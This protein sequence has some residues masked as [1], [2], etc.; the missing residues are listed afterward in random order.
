MAKLAL[1]AL[2]I[3]L[4]LSCG[5]AAEPADAER[6]PAL[7][8]KFLD[9]FNARNYDEALDRALAYGAAVSQT[10][11]QGSRE[12][13][14]FQSLLAGTFRGQ[15]KFEMAETYYLSAVET[16][17]KA[18]GANHADVADGYSVT[19]SFYELMSGIV[20]TGQAKIEYLNKAI[21]HAERALSI[22]ETTLGLADA[23][24]RSS[25]TTLAR[26]LES[27]GDLYAAEDMLQRLLRIREETLGTDHLEVAET[28]HD[29]ASVS[30][31]QRRFDV[32]LGLIDRAIGI[33]QAE[34]AAEDARLTSSLNTRAVVLSA[35]GDHAAAAEILERILP[36]R[37]AAATPNDPN[38]AALLANLAADYVET[39][40]TDK[41]E[42][43]Y[44]RVAKMREEF[45]G[46]AHPET[47]SARSALARLL[48]ANGQ[49]V[50]AE[51]LLKDVLAV[52]ETD[53]GAD[54]I[55]DSGTLKEL[56]SLYVARAHWP[57]AYEYYR[58]SSE[59]ILSRTRADRKKF[60]RR[61]SGR[62]SDAVKRNRYA[63][64][65]QV[66][67]GH[68]LSRKLEE[69]REVLKDEG[70]QL[71]QVAYQ[72]DTGAALMQ[73]AARSVTGDLA[74]LLR[75]RQDL[76]SQWQ[77]LDGDIVASSGDVD[78]AERR[79]QLR[80]AQMQLDVELDTVEQKLSSEF[81]R[82]A[83]LADA[84]PLSLAATRALLSADEA[85][86]VF[87]MGED[88]GL[89]WVA[90]REAAHWSRLLFGEAFMRTYVTGLRCGLDAES[91]LDPIKAETCAKLVQERGTTYDLESYENGEP[92][93]FQLDAAY[94]LY[95][96]L[97]QDVAPFIKDKSLIVVPSGTLTQLPFQALVT[98][99]PDS[100]ATYAKAR[101]LIRSH[102]LTVLPSVAALRGLR[103]HAIR[104][105]A[106]RPY[107]G[108]GNP[109]LDGPDEHYH[110]LAEQARAHRACEGLRPLQVA[111]RRRSVQLAR[112]V[113]LPRLRQADVAH[114]RQQSPL[115]ETADEVCAVARRQNAS[116][117]DVLLAGAATESEV[118]RLSA[119]GVL[120][121]Y[122]ILHFATHGAMAG[123]LAGSAEPGL[124]L[125]PPDQGSAHDDGYLSA[126][127]I[128]DLKLNA[129]WV[130][131]SACNTAAG[132]GEGAEALSGLARSFFYAGARTLLVS[133]W[134]VASEP[135]VKLIA[136]AFEASD[137]APGL[138]RA[139]VLR[140]SMISMID[141][142]DGKLSH[143]E[144]WSPFIL[145]GEG[146]AR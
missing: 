39:G 141:D 84:R 115:P 128:A 45:Y 43:L 62:T 81:P 114:I 47:V 48:K 86:V 28:L 17:K 139:E 140:R 119:D 61:L 132:A 71:A 110:D 93:P 6:L 102:A 106:P 21:R 35:I 5:A 58:R 107:F 65:E 108:I 136:G 36:I 3:L 77:S 105:R 26:L 145:V 131:L 42:E 31:A 118:K 91:W 69:R 78:G 125:T 60:A 30:L 143:P 97:F 75:K 10:V 92:L 129:D 24:S 19:A 54:S 98:A 15:G 137:N 4:G 37:E 144:Y 120:A 124:I 87:L 80:R 96:Q 79:K 76:I 121:K 85:L 130:I 57:K 18:L 59:I 117:P 34:L 134:A 146:A 126:S 11:G 52:A 135:T 50:E 16:L 40:R 67:V 13:A 94:L 55:D 142:E 38:I 70:F 104:E 49:D 90:T 8:Q 74:P 95:R 27:R 101:W 100:D 20:M 14:H 111:G 99:K 73:M 25:M 46:A 1:I 113:R 33:R 83:E 103:Q 122:R 127:E 66:L 109:L 116:D 63:F 29:L 2:S 32:A 89:V 72:S 7:K 44:R 138:P 22:R 9:S 51:A 68:S 23:L 53:L 82:Y 56:A 64:V 133:H 41:A 123:E 112:G 12:Y 88:D